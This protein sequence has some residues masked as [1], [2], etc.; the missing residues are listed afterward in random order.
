MAHSDDADPPAA[1]PLR[2]TRELPRLNHDDEP[3]SASH[4]ARAELGEELAD[5]RGDLH[6]LGAQ[7]ARSERAVA[8]LA[9]ALDTLLQILRVRETLGEGHLQMLDAVRKHA[10]LAT[11]PQLMLGTTV[12]KYVVE[13][14]ADLD[15]SA[16]V[17]LCQSRCCAL[18][19]P[20]SEQDL[21]EGK[22]AWRIRAP[23][24]LAQDDTGYCVYLQHA[25]GGCGNYQVRP[26]PCRSYDCRQDPRVWIDYE[27]RIPA[28]MPEGLVTIR[29]RD[30]RAPG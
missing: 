30:A 24:Y 2:M 9:T 28:P 19:I 3:P 23:Y 16:L 7:V 17:H 10:K 12:D 13:S 4:D 20:L 22:L 18:N 25:T 11:E 6:R 27:R 29:R 14:P 1:P 5:L 8:G 21:T 26:A 15:C